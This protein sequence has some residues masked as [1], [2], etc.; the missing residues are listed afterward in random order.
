MSV[1]VR[2]NDDIDEINSRM[3]EMEREKIFEGNLSP[4]TLC[5]YIKVSI[6]TLMTL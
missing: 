4:E 1:K 5:E 3:I 2:K 6:E